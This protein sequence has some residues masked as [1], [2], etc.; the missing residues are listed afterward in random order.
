LPSSVSSASRNC[1]REDGLRREFIE[2]RGTDEEKNIGT[3]LRR[4]AI[5]AVVTTL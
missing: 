4:I 2:A 3:L 5:R 1:S